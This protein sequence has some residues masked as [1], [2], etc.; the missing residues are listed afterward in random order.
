[1]IFLICSLVN[2]SLRVW[3]E[4]KTDLEIIYEIKKMN[5]EEII[6]EIDK[7]IELSQKEAERLRK[8]GRFLSETK[9]LSKV[10]AY[11][12]VKILISKN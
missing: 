10:V 12:E 11:I 9:H 8:T 6:K 4:F 2:A 1:M 5:K 7:L 3:S